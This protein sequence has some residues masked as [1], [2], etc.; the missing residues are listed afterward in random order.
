MSQFGYVNV[1]RSR[2]NREFYVG[3]A[4]ESKRRLAENNAGEVGSMRK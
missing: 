3:F 1:L 4:A 2:R